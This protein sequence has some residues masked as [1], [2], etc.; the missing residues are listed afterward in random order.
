MRRD[1]AMLLGLALASATLA[2]KASPPKPELFGV[3]RGCTKIKA[4]RTCL[5]TSGSTLTVWFDASA[6]STVEVEIDGDEIAT[7]LIPAEDG[8]RLELPLEDHA[9][10]VRVDMKG[11]RFELPLKWVETATPAEAGPR[12]AYRLHQAGLR[13]LRRGDA[14]KAHRLLEEAEDLARNSKLT[15]RWREIAYALTYLELTALG[16]FTDAEVRRN[17]LPEA[18]SYDGRAIVLLAWLNGIT[19]WRLGDLRAA[20]RH[21]DS[22]MRWAARL[23]APTKSEA[24]SLHGLLLL[25]M[26][27]AAEAADFFDAREN[28]STRGSC[29]W[30]TDVLNAGWAR[31]MLKEPRS[32]R[33]AADLFELGLRAFDA[34]CPDNDTRNHQAINLALAEIELGDSTSAR[35][36]LTEVRE[37]LG[38]VQ[39]FWVDLLNARLELADGHSEDAAGRF[40]ALADRA[41]RARIHSLEWRARLGAGRAFRVSSDVARATTQLIAAEDILDREVH[42]MPAH[43]GRFAWLNDRNES[44]TEL[45]QMLLE[46]GHTDAAFSAARRARRR[47]YLTLAATAQ[48]GRLRA[49]RDSAW[50]LRVAAFEEARRA[51]SAHQTTDS[52]STPESDSTRSDAKERALASE[53]D[54]RMVEALSLL[55]PRKISLDPAPRSGTT[56]ALP[57]D[58]IAGPQLFLQTATGV[59]ITPSSAGMAETLAQREPTPSAIVLL[60]TRPET[61][62][63]LFRALGSSTPVAFGLD[64]GSPDRTSVPLR[65]RLIVSDPRGDL[66]D[67]REE[68]NS[69]RLAWKDSKVT[70][71]TGQAA[72]REA[73]VTAL[74]S[75]DYFHYAGHGRSAGTEGWESALLLAESELTVADVLLLGSAPR[76]VILSG[77]ETAKTGAATSGGIGLAQAFLVAGSDAV[78]ATHRSVPSAS[79]K[80]YAT[81]LHQSLTGTAATDIYAAHRTALDAMGDA[82]DAFVLLVR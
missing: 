33:E 13:A 32:I 52:W 11:G 74:R 51:L 31:L 8:A 62:S 22:S 12:E 38:P 54:H 41:Q 75:A 55:T 35:K 36:W 72:T 1:R 63:T 80:A 7:K 56:V 28:K 53:V 77:C 59:T 47:G 15:H 66:A 73:V 19:D 21:I 57:V 58:T 26:G 79:A 68:A 46:R 10:R 44:S 9:E 61:S 40:I 82:A 76:F 64:L 14:E 70:H 24:S 60:S 17:E 6:S 78:I 3:F 25:E 18:P 2:C 16:E 27:R 69:V 29:L 34:D 65:D 50:G 30:A 43:E 4:D 37:P 23:D 81:A 48:I 5:Y 71:L 42:L 45:I 49:R 39:R 67:A 20:S